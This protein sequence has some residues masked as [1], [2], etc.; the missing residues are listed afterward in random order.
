MALLAQGVH[1]RRPATAPAVAGRVVT[2]PTTNALRTATMAIEMF[3]R[4]ATLFI[5]QAVTVVAFGAMLVVQGGWQAAASAIAMLGGFV[6]LLSYIS[7]LARGERLA[8]ERQRLLRAPAQTTQQVRAQ[9]AEPRRL[10]PAP[11]AAL[12][13][14]APRLRAV[15]PLSGAP[16]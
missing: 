5:S 4:I 6:F 2:R 8:S 11:D 9:P 3:H 10:A 13:P 14:V 1:S 12:R 16:S 7:M 15:G